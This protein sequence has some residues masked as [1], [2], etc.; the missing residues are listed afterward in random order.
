M[1]IRT[2]NGA[3]SVHSQ[4]N[5]KVSR[6]LSLFRFLIIIEEQMERSWKRIRSGCQFES[7]AV[8]PEK[9]VSLHSS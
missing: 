8:M 1:S 9:T 4:L 2:N 3:E 6:K 7:R 5:P